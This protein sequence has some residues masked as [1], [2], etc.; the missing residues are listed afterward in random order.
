[1][2]FQYVRVHI[3]PSPAADHLS[4]TTVW[5]IYTVIEDC[6]VH[7]Q[8]CDDALALYQTRDVISDDPL[9][10]A[11]AAKEGYILVMGPKQFAR[12]GDIVALSDAPPFLGVVRS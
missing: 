12:P 1:M 10:N 2:K 7:E 11:K 3:D 9:A 8:G 4:L 5:P 6:G